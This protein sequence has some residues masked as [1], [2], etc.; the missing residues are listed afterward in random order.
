MKI[1]IA[2]F[3]MAVRRMATC[4]GLSSVLF[5]GSEVQLKVIAPLRPVFGRVG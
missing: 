5:R 4:V 2:S 3:S 1:G